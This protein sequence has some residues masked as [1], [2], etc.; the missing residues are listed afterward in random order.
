M[1][2]FYYVFIFEAH[3]TVTSASL[4]RFNTMQYFKAG[5][6]CRYSNQMKWTI[7]TIQ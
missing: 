6:P 7:V 1:Y 5:Y 3:C 4:S 2:L